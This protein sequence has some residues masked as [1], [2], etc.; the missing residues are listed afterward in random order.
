MFK[1]YLEDFNSV[2][3]LRLMCFSKSLCYNI[4]GLSNFLF[5]QIK[6]LTLTSNPWKKIVRN[7]LN[8]L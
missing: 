1:R 5:S 7:I 3:M 4:L 8:F 2:C 6:D